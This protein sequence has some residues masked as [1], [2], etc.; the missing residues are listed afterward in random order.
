[1][2][3]RALTIAFPCA[4]I[5][6]VL[7]PLAVAAQAPSTVDPQLALRVVF[8]SKL[9]DARKEAIRLIR[10]IE[11]G[12]GGAQEAINKGRLD[13]I[14][15]TDIEE[16][17]MQLVKLKR[18]GDQLNAWGELAG[19]DIS[20]RS[21]SYRV[22]LTK[23]AEQRTTDREFLNRL[24]IRLKKAEAEIQMA[25]RR[26]PEVT[27]LLSQKPEQA[28]EAYWKLTDRIEHRNIWY[29]LKNIPNQPASLVTLEPTR[30]A[31]Y[32]AT[33]ALWKSQA[34]K[35]SAAALAASKADYAK[36]VKQANDAAAA[37]GKGAAFE[38]AGKKLSGPAA[39]AELGA[40]WQQLDGATLHAR[41]WA[42]Y[43]GRLGG[44]NPMGVLAV[45]QQTNGHNVAA[46]LGRIV[47]ADANRAT[48]DDAVKLYGEYLDKLTPLVL[49]ASDPSIRDAFQKPLDDLAARSPELLAEVQAYHNAT[50]EILRW[51]E[52][53]A[54]AMALARMVQAPPIEKLARAAA[55]PIN[56]GK[57]PLLVDN[58]SQLVSRYTGLVPDLIGRLEALTS[59]QAAA[60]DLLGVPPGITP[61]GAQAVSNYQQ[62]IRCY[63]RLAP[64]AT[65]AAGESIASLAADLLSSPSQAPLTLDGRAALDGAKQADLAAAGGPILRLGLV[66]W[67][68]HFA[69]LPIEQRGA[70]RIGPLLP[71]D[72][73]NN[74]LIVIAEIDARWLAG[75]YY[76]VDVPVADK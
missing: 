8:I 12:L 58:K 34:Q 15:E 23:I 41:G 75:R 6:F 21:E 25:L 56:Q 40:R 16:L 73:T 59:K 28:Q 53:I 74:E 13:Q 11:K 55:S 70:L 33:Q 38:L 39:V 37:I 5:V 68:E 44:P 14:S 35:A 27:R 32:S 63:V 65:V 54:E 61:A 9:G 67:G 50:D 43:S 26:L 7:F 49:L 1:M 22:R 64:V 71:D 66:A 29:G 20:K 51:R 62:P 45:A 42:W 69:N 47:A 57:G 18:L 52:R 17:H 30:N 2:N 19:V 46:A 3:E 36:L 76:F 48:P 31:C 60:V 24:N 72:V 10:E 4:L